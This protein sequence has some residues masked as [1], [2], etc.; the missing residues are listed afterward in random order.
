MLIGIM[1]RGDAAPLQSWLLYVTLVLVSVQGGLWGFRLTECLGLYDPLVILPLMTGIYILFGGMAG[2]I[3]FQEYSALPEGRAGLWNWLLYCVGFIFVLWGLYLVRTDVIS[4]A[5]SPAAN[6][7]AGSSP[8]RDKSSTSGAVV[9]ATAIDVSIELP[10]NGS[11][12]S[13]GA[14]GPSAASPTSASLAEGRRISR[15]AS[16]P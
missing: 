15:R 12:G 2:G 1:F 13:P 8:P 4:G 5:G 6:A 7:S 9:S 14:E 3:F 10:N 11:N 16:S